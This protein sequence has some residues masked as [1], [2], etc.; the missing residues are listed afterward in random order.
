MVVQRLSE[1]V[2]PGPIH[3]VKKVLREV[4]V[5][6]IAKQV[7]VPVT[8]DHTLPAGTAAL[9]A[10]DKRA[11][12]EQGLSAPEIAYVESKLPEKKLKSDAHK[13][14]FEAGKAQRVRAKL[15]ERLVA[16]FRAD[17]DLAAGVLSAVGVALTS[18][19]APTA[20]LPAAAPQVATLSDKVS[21]LLAFVDE[22]GRDV[23]AY[24]KQAKVGKSYDKDKLRVMF[25]PEAERDW[26]LSWFAFS[27]MVAQAAGTG[28]ARK[29]GW[30]SDEGLSR[31]AAAHGYKST[32]A[33]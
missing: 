13:A 30:D 5:G 22:V 33:A 2:G 20:S 32:S 9:T 3:V 15:K 12:A 7:R 18:G 25:T 4:S 10:S 26:K 14:V 1:G 21:R 29:R 6:S 24:K 11:L 28:F 16:Q 19:D 27:R 17:P 23:E 31:L 8:L